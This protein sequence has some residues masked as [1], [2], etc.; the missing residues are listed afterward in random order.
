MSSNKRRTA[1]Q[2]VNSAAWMETN[3]DGRRHRCR[4][5][6]ISSNGARLIVDNVENTPDIFN[7]LLS[8]FGRPL[9]HCN[10]VWR[11]GDEVGVEFLDSPTQ[12]ARESAD[13]DHATAI[14]SDLPE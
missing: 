8:R 10:V 6:D 14:V 11:R 5:V 3:G 4:L 9:Y 12:Q 2:T 7:L 1:R 13:A